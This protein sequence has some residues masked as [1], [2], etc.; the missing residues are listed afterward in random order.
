MLVDAGAIP[1]LGQVMSAASGATHALTGVA[2]HVNDSVCLF[3]FF[4]SESSLAQTF[5]CVLNLSCIFVLAEEDWGKE[6]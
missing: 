5:F 3:S 6:Y 2:R 4:F 1:M